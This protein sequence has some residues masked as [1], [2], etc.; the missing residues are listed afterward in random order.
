MKHK[1]LPAEC[2]ACGDTACPV[3]LDELTIR[4][5]LADIRGLSD[6]IASREHVETLR[7]LMS[8]TRSLAAL[9]DAFHGFTPDRRASAP[10]ERER[11]IAVPKH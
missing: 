8:Q 9:V 1:T 5:N 11:Y 4:A 6:C 7:A 2:P 10:R 3:I